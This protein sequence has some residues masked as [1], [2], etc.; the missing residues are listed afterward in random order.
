MSAPSTVSAAGVFDAPNGGAAAG[1][2]GR[3]QGRLDGSARVLAIA[4]DPG[5]TERLPVVRRT[6]N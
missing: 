2:F 1:T 3:Y 5:P 4:S 6:L